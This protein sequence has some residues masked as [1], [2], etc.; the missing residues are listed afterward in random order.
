MNRVAHLS[1]VELRLLLRRKTTAVSVVLVPLG[2]AALTHF[3]TRPPDVAEWG[4]LLARN[5]LLLMILSVYMVSLTVFT[6]RRQSLVLK[7]LRTSELRDGEVLAGVVGPVVLVGL[8]QTLGYYAFCLAIGAPIPAAPGLL[9][10]GIALAL[11]TA[12]AMGVATACLTRSVEATQLTGVPP[13]IAA[14]AGMFL[15]A[16][17]VSGPTIVGLA[18]PLAGPVDLVA[19]GWGAPGALVADVPVVPLDLAS[20][21]LWLTVAGV[22]FN[23]L[24]RWE[25]RA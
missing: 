7:R 25:P 10:L 1:T 11:V 21:V 18:M 5:F 12:T 15:T 8:A 2:L 9:A 22:L 3:G 4:G 13:L 17:G 16:T 14:L 23:R 20:T 19:K 24:F 6:A